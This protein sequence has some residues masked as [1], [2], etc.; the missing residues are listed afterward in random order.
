MYNQLSKLKLLG[1]FFYKF[2]PFNLEFII[3]SPDKN[4]EYLQKHENI[5]FI[6][7]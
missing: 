7:F 5:L 4:P 6:N 2:I 1:I 3:N